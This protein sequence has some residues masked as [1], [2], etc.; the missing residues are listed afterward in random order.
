MGLFT[1]LAIG[2]ALAGGMFAGKKL[3]PTPQADSGGRMTPNGATQTAQAEPPLAPPEPPKSN[4][5]PAQLAA[6]AAGRKQRRRATS[7][8]P[9][10]G[11]VNGFLLGPGIGTN[12][13]LQPKTLLGR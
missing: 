12:A 8:R 2:A 13:S 6:A 4:R 11:A 10:L 5:G 7:G 9:G 1:S 3:A